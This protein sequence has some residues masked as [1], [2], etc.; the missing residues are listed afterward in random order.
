MI[1]SQCGEEMVDDSPLCPRC[2]A[3]TSASP[4]SEQERPGRRQ[5]GYRRSFRSE[6]DS[7]P[8]PR[9]R[10][11]RWSPAD[12][13]AV[14]GTSVLFVSLFLPWFELNAFRVTKSGLVAHDYL[15]VVLILCLIVIAYLVS[16]ARREPPGFERQVSHEQLLLVGTGINL[17][18]VLVAFVAK[19]TGAG[20]F[21]FGWTYGSFIAVASAIVAFVPLALPKRPGRLGG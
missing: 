17:V 7:G 9:F 16:V 18:L 21:E 10:I 13:A 11:N 1:C 4:A 6:G 15:Y 8:P 5:G 2:G 20:I 14:V 12:R 3:G 19:P